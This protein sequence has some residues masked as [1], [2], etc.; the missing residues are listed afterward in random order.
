MNMEKNEW[1]KKIFF[2]VLI[3]NLIFLFNFVKN[4]Y[5][6]KEVLWEEDFNKLEEGEETGFTLLGGREVNIEV[7]SKIANGGKGKALKISPKEG[8]DYASNYNLFGVSKD[9]TFPN[10]DAVLTF[11]YYAKG[12]SGI[13][14]MSWDQVVNENCDGVISQMAFEKWTKVVLRYDKFKV[15]GGKGTVKKGDGFRHIHF[16][17]SLNPSV[18]LK[19]QFVVLDDIKLTIGTEEEK[20]TK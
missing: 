19:D 15:K 4:V 11:Y 7:Q 9:I 8:V 5:A 6:A 13:G 18:P 2:G 12:V 16:L 14:V 10:E 1:I 17:F 3:L 20:P